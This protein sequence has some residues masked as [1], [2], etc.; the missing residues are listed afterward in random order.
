MLGGQAHEILGTKVARQN[1]MQSKKKVSSFHLTAV[2]KKML[3]SISVDLL[4][5]VII[6]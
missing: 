6:M 2:C 4:L 5:K 3:K 1:L